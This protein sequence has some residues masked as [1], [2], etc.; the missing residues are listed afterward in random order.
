MIA[1]ETPKDSLSYVEDC[2]G[3]SMYQAIKGGIGQSKLKVTDFLTI[4]PN[5]KILPI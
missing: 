5:C 1:K 3:Y 4:N 2:K